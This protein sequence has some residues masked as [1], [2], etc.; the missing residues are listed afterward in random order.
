M[1]D[2]D[3][4]SHPENRSDIPSLTLPPDGFASRIPAY[5][6]EG[7]SEA[8]QYILTEVS[9]NAAFAEWSAKALIEITERLRHTN[10]KVSIM[11]ALK[12]TLTGYRGLL[13]GLLGLV[14]SL[15]GFVE[16]WNFAASHLPHAENVV[17]LAP[18]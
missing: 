10:G 8:E 6:L 13:I 11:W 2:E 16:V 9:K 4:E 17:E 1:A 18:K 15:A 14:G 5:L 3:D 7:K 12:S